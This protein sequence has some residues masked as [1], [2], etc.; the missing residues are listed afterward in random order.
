MAET[1]VVT[2]NTPFLWEGTDRKG[3]KVKGKT[4]ATRYAKRSRGRVQSRR[5][6]SLGVIRRGPVRYSAR[7]YN[8]TLSY[9][10]RSRYYRSRPRYRSHPRRLIYPGD[11]Y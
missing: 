11:R 1:A 8:R 10:P 2:S 9:L 6:R 5:R 4:M 3:N 7:S